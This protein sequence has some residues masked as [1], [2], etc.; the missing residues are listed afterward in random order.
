MDMDVSD[1]DCEVIVNVDANKDRPA[2]NDS[3][4]STPW[5]MHTNNTSSNL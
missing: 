2:L 3:N 4:N 5:T 1:N